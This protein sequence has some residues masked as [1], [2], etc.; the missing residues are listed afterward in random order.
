[1]QSGQAVAWAEGGMHW[2]RAVTRVWVCF[3]AVNEFLVLVHKTDASA[4][5]GL[6]GH[7]LLAALPKGLVLKTPQ[8]RQ[9]LLT[10]PYPF[11]RKFGHDKVL[12]CLP[13]GPPLPLQCQGPQ[14]H[15]G[16]PSP[17]VC[18]LQACVGPLGRPELSGQASMAQ[19][20]R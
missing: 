12:G 8:S 2:G 13:Q 14:E 9:S 18:L 10:W 6:S 11:L 1:M 5:C 20:P 16:R 19:H 4:R 15:R 17:A 3:P 7:Y